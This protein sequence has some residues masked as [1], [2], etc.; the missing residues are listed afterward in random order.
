MAKCKKDVTPLLTH[1]SYVFLALTDRNITLRGIGIENRRQANMPRNTDVTF[2]PYH[3]FH[4]APDKYLWREKLY[5]CEIILV[6][7]IPRPH[8]IALSAVDFEYFG[9]MADVIKLAI[10]SK[11]C[12]LEGYGVM[13]CNH[14]IMQHNKSGRMCIFLAMQ[15]G[16]TKRFKGM[17]SILL[18]IKTYI[19]I[20]Y[21]WSHYYEWYNKNA[22]YV[23]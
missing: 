22:E 14:T 17:D 8:T 10:C 1:W 5:H 7:I 19:S 16:N 6:Y 11:A 21:N 15:K 20:F 12:N 9:D 4:N 2:H 23:A 18:S 13:C 3:K